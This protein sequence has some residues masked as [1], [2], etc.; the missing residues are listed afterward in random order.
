[1]KNF[2]LFTVCLAASFSFATEII[3]YECSTVWTSEFDIECKYVRIGYIAP[4]EV[5]V[6]WTKTTQCQWV[7]GNT[8]LSFQRCVAEDAFVANVPGMWRFVC[9]YDYKD[10]YGIWRK[11]QQTSDRYVS[12]CEDETLTLQA[13]TNLAIPDNYAGEMVYIDRPLDYHIRSITCVPGRTIILRPLVNGVPITITEEV[14]RIEGDKVLDHRSDLL[15]LLCSDNG[16]VLQF[17]A[18]NG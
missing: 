18:D 13:E 5:D 1:M 6:I 7:L 12:E 14:G 10:I 8:D 11:S 16:V 4:G 3:P 2:V 15:G 17:F 9:Q